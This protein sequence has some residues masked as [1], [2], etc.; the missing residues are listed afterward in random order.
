MYMSVASPTHAYFLWMDTHS[1]HPLL[2]F[3]RL[4]LLETRTLHIGTTYRP[5]ACHILFYII[6]LESCIAI[7]F[8]PLLAI[9][10]WQ[11]IGRFISRPTV[12][13]TRRHFLRSS[14][15]PKRS[16]P[17]TELLSSGITCHCVHQAPAAAAAAVRRFLWGFL[18]QLIAMRGPRRASANPPNVSA[19]ISTFNIH[20]DSSLFLF[21]IINSS[22]VSAGTL[23]VCGCG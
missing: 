22:A 7:K 13:S 17:R 11:T 8:F 6:T 20:F 21:T 3:Y 2:V 4:L 9:N 14:D 15:Q 19:F 23:A 5:T 12:V 18:H 1:F 16:T 10:K